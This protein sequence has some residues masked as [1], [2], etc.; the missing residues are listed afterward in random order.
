VGGSIV[1]WAVAGS[2]QAILALWGII[3]APIT[4]SMWYVAAMGYELSQ[5]VLRA[6][7]L[8]DDL[9]E[10]QQRI[11]LA[12]VP[13]IWAS[14]FEILCG[15]KSGRPTVAGVVGSRESV[16]GCDGIQSGNVV[17]LS[18]LDATH[19]RFIG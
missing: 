16:L 7:R 10:S 13:P 2:V 4:T 5:D 15:M 19:S 11:A 1:F 9:R 8:S 17:V 14:G 3:H 6:A 12:L 18:K